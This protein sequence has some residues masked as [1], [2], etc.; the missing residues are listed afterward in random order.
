MLA[1]PRLATPTVAPT[2]AMLLTLPFLAAACHSQAT[3]EGKA[4]AAAVT[5]PAP[6]AVDTVAVEE[7]PMPEYL[8]VTGTLLPN[9]ESK[10]AAGVSGKV[11]TTYVERGTQIK[12]GAV[13][14][15]LDTR[16]VSANIAEARATASAARTQREQARTDCE[17]SQALYAKGAMPK[18]EFDR[19]QSQC[20]ATQ[21]QADAAEARARALSFNLGD[22]DIRSP[23]SGSVVERSIS[24][25]EYVQAS[26]VVA[27]VAQLDPLRLEL[28]VPESAVQEMRPGLVVEFRLAANESEHFSGT[29]RYIGPSVRRSSRDLLVEAVVDNHDRRLLPGMFATARIHIGD[30]KRPVVP[31]SAVRDEGSLHHLFVVHDGRLE[32]RLVQ[33]GEKKDGLVAV[34]DGV[35]P[36]EQVAKTPASLT[37]GQP[38]TAPSKGAR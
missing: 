30:P 31:V 7:R 32:E 36:G 12:K 13:L 26:T 15:V 21:A 35:K 10:V 8:L 38:V 17:R 37:D 14:A 18:A 3:A 33:L 25:G 24:A 28:S 19:L 2:V 9:Q 4:Q 34:L 1:H 5:D 6:V 11:L 22:A 27:T 23:F 20:L 16:T 29:V